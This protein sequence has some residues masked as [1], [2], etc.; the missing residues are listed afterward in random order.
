MASR[1]AR[2]G[3][4]VAVHWLNHAAG[5]V[6]HADAVHCQLLAHLP[7]RWLK[8]ERHGGLRI[9]SWQLA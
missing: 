9:D 3:E 6:L 5:H 1:M 2:G 7:L 8:G 4:F